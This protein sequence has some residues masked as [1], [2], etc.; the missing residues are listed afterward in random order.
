MSANDANCLGSKRGWD[1]CD[2]E[3]S[4]EQ[5]VV[6][7][8]NSSWLEW[9]ISL[10]TKRTN[11]RAGTD[12]RSTRESFGEVWGFGY[13]HTDSADVKGLLTCGW[14]EELASIWEKVRVFRPKAEANFPPSF[15]DLTIRLGVQ[16]G[17]FLSTPSTPSAAHSGVVNLH[18][19]S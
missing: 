19:G 1:G 3:E 8:I 17:V 10:T 6:E 18:P 9:D 4:R 15:P 2:E 14:R 7:Y 16:S 13:S 5:S 11:A 12:S